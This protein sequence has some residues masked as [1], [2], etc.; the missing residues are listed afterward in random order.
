[1]KD[2]T[3]AP[4][5]QLGM[6]LP[7]SAIGTWPEEVWETLPED[8]RRETLRRLARLLSRWLESRRRRS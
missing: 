6:V 7:G 4:V 8:V 5:C 3:I 1:M 2:H